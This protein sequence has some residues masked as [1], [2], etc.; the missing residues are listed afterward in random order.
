MFYIRL[1]AGRRT[2]RKLEKRF[3]GQG[4]NLK[5]KFKINQNQATILRGKANGKDQEVFSDES[6]NATEY[7]LIIALVS[8]ESLGAGAWGPHF[9]RTQVTVAAVC[10][11]DGGARPAKF[12]SKAN[13]KQYPF[14]GGM[15]S[16]NLFFSRLATQP[17]TP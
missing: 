7:G 10:P 3:M 2:F 9:R 4:R 16:L 6:G 17:S 1:A 13:L 5:A 8:V 11:P 12:F 14:K 15:K